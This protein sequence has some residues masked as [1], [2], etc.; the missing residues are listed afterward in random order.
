MTVNLVQISSFQ[1]Y[2]PQRANEEKNPYLA[3]QLIIYNCFKFESEYYTKE[4][5]KKITFINFRKTQ[6]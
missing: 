6:C 1:K 4:G 2:F 3:K 5:E